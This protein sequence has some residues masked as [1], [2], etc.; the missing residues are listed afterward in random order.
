VVLK[1]RENNERMISLSRQYLLCSCLRKSKRWCKK[2][3][4]FGK[5][6]KSD[7]KKGRF[8]CVEKRREE[9]REEKRGAEKKW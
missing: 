1:K 9:K 6:N 4:L 3:S 5:I 2:S 7:Q 8:C